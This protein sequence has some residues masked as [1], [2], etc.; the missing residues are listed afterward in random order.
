MKLDITQDLEVAH[1]ITREEFEEKYYYPQ[2]PV[3]LKGL[4]DPFPAAKK[5]D[6]QYFKDEMGDTEVGI[7]DASLERVDR[8]Y[9]EPHY[10]M[11]F[12]D[13]L[14]EI[15][16]GPTKKRLFLFN[17][18]KFHPPLLKDFEF[19]KICGGFIKSFPFM[20]FGGDGSITR[21]HQDVDLSCVFLTQFTG[22]KR[23]VLF[24]P[25][26]SHLLYRFPFN[27]HTA[28]DIDNP[29]FDKYPALRYVKGQEA[30]LEFGDTIFMPPG[31]WH[32]IEYVGSGFSMSLRCLSPSKLHWLRGGWNV[33]VQTHLDEVLRNVLGEKWWLNYKERKA[34]ELAEKAMK[35]IGGFSQSLA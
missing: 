29:D 22:K 1:N 3:I 10:K 30:I 7:F 25:K 2:K 13:Y 20:F 12:R 27:V 23:V 24:D 34:Q 19:P 26:Y 16:A 4:V 31:W 15:E 6:F 17:A 11:P 33:A 21:A 35:K 5:W 14:D 18:F 28:V 9:K 8:A 32:H